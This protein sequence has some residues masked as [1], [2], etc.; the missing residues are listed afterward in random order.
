M[1]GAKYGTDARNPSKNRHNVVFRIPLT[2]NGVHLR[3]LR[4]LGVLRN[5]GSWVYLRTPAEG[6][7]NFVFVSHT[8]YLEKGGRYGITQAEDFAGGF[9]PAS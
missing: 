1:L 2:G 6:I 8:M 5:R 7:R 9:G 3:L 4:S